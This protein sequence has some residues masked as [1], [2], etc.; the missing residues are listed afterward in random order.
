[1]AQEIA[2][3]VQHV[4]AQI[5]AIRPGEGVKLMAVTKMRTR[6]E[7][8][9]AVAAGAQLIGENKVQ[10]AKDKWH[11]KPPVPL[12]LIGHLQTNKVKYTIDLFDSVDSIDSEK[13]AEALNQRVTDRLAVMLEI[14]AG[15]EAS[16]TGMFPQHVRAFLEQAH[17]WPHLQFIGMMALFPSAVGTT[18]D[19]KKKIRALMKETGELWRTCREERFPWAPL[20]E[21]SMG[22]TDD[23]EWALEA[24]TTIVRLGTALFGPRTY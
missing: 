9:A 11:E 10:E 14:N 24:G 23:Y 22:M 6:E 16:K 3:R 15:Q 12:H 2:E 8:L 13:V 20:D 17:R 1:M 4:L 18:L 19:E 21:L 5:E 7:A